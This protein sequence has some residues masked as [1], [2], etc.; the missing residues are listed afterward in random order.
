MR[1]NTSHYTVLGG[2]GMNC[3]QRG[4]RARS[5]QATIITLL[6]MGY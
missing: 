3:A 2:G 5:I 1:T 4:P 6:I